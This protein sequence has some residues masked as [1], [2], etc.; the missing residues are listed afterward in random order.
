MIIHLS[1]QYLLHTRMFEELLLHP[2]IFE[3]LET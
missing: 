1:N 3:E 2:R